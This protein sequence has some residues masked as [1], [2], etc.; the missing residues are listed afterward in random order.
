VRWDV[1]AMVQLH[2][3]L[4]VLKIPFPFFLSQKKRTTFVQD[5]HP[6]KKPNKIQMTVSGI[7]MTRLESDYI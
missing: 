4:G 6:M 3:Q 1:Q 7:L 2:L 5:G